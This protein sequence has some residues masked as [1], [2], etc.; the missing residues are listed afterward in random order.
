M[1]ERW[2]SNLGG[3]MW[4]DV[5]VQILYDVYMWSLHQGGAGWRRGSGAAPHITLS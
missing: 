1:M 4:K 3:R 2:R 5:E